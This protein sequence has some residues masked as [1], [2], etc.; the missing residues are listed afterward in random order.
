MDPIVLSVMERYICGSDRLILYHGTDSSHPLILKPRSYLTTDFW[1]AASYGLDKTDHKE[2]YIYEYI[3]EDPFKIINP[4]EKNWW[5]QLQRLDSKYN[6]EMGHDAYQTNE[7]LKPSGKKWHL[8]RNTDTS[9]EFK[10]WDDYEITP[11]PPQARHSSE[12]RV[13]II[14]KEKGEY[15]VRSP[16]NPDWSGGCYP[17]KGEAE[18]RLRQVEYFKHKS[19]DYAIASRV[20]E[21]FLSNPKVS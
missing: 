1:A 19:A 21:R 11:R 20:V 12:V 15:C 4:E 5:N 9:D 2:C 8:V 16:N 7:P 10:G 13:A 3:V 6:V 17:S 14:R 18:D